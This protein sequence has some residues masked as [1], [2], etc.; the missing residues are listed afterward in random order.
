MKLL[1]K[2]FF[3]LFMYGLL[4]IFSILSFTFFIFPLDDWSLLYQAKLFNLSYPVVIVGLLA[5]FAMLMAIITSITWRQ[6]AVYIE[7]Q[8]ERLLHDEQLLTENYNELKKIDSYINKLHSK[9]QQQIEHAQQL[10][11]KHATEREKSLQEVVIQ[12]RSRLARDL[13]DSVSQQLFAASMM[14]SAINETEKLESKSISKQLHTVEDMIQQSQLEMRA[15]LLHLRPVALKGKSLQDG[16][17]QFLEELEE[18]IP[19]DLERNIETFSV[20]K[21]IEDQLFRVL[22]EALSNALRHA[23]PS[24]IKVIL[25]KR[26]HFIILRIQDDGKGFNLTEVQAGSYGLESMKERARD[27][28]GTC[29]IVTLPEKG[30][31]V[32]IKIPIQEKTGGENI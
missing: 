3:I 6:S 22:Q 2:Q 18:R 11:T 5:V 10:A 13:H 28:G 23:E 26:D 29:K 31:R 4:I 32:E 14:M 8:L 9:N 25:I 1:L 21:G 16:I 12:E 27:L 7:K 24:S 20:E 19:I 17:K 30:T 15:L